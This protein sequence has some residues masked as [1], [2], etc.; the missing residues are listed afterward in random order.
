MSAPE[1]SRHLA[2][3][4]NAGIINATRQGR[5]V[6]CEVDLV[7]NARLGTDLIEALLR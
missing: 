2:G 6:V 1:V 3:L 7:G 5:Y 4:K